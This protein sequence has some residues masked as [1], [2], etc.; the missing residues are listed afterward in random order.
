[1]T[2]TLDRY[3][4]IA[5]VYDFLDLPFE[6]GRYR[7]IRPHLFGGL[8][9]RILDAGIG[10]GRNIPFYPPNAHVVGIVT[11]GSRCCRSVSFAMSFNC[12]ARRQ[13]GALTPDPVR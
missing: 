1:M 4:R 3:Q 8:S 10:T 9:G 11:N 6:F 2:S 5:P 7:R 12:I 13:I